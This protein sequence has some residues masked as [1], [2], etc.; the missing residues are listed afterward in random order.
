MT[1]YNYNRRVS[2]FEYYI[3]SFKW[4]L[5]N[6]VIGL[7]P[8]LFMLAIKIISERNICDEEIEH[9]IS[10]GV[11]LFVCC[12]IMGSILIDFILGGHKLSSGVKILVVYLPLLILAFLL[13]DYF[14][15]TQRMTTNTFHLSTPVSKFVILFSFVYCIF[16]KT[17]LYMKE[18]TKS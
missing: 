14:L 7:S 4:L 9:L 2:H 1:N 13:L 6:A 5:G 16:S 10:D 17:V 15:M 12:A 8:L 11:I 3:K 18:D